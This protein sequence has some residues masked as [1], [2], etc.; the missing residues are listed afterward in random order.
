MEH[1]LSSSGSKVCALATK[2]MLDLSTC[3]GLRERTLESILNSTPTQGQ[4]RQEHKQ[5]G[6]QRCKVGLSSQKN[7]LRACDP[8]SL[9]DGILCQ[10]VCDQV[11]EAAHATFRTSRTSRR[12]KDVRYPLF[13][14]VSWR[15][16]VRCLSHLD[17]ECR[18]ATQ[19][20]GKDDCNMQTRTLIKGLTQPPRFAKAR[21][22]RRSFVPL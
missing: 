2:T 1:C 16:T 9:V 17:M 22:L 6:S 21:N 19:A 4:D 11:V 13:N 8:T 5:T 7:D 15:S 12:E 10:A 14:D 18:S 3:P 20:A